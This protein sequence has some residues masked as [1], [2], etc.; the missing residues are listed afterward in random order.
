MGTELRGTMIPREVRAEG[1]AVVDTTL[2]GRLGS[3]PS[4]YLRAQVVPPDRT[5][6][7]AWYQAIQVCTHAHEVYRGFL[8]EQGFGDFISIPTFRTR[9]SLVQALAEHWFS[10]TNTLHLGDCELC[11]KIGRA[12]CR[13]RVFN[14]V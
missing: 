10:E 9:H 8:V 13:E 1:E 6:R 3:H 5:F 11:V 14:W 2:L 12:S 7:G 4:V